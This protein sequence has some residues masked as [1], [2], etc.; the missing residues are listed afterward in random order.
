M[1]DERMI[2]GGLTCWLAAGVFLLG[3]LV[4]AVRLEDVQI[5]SKLE[6]DTSMERQST[7]RV[8]TAG[9][10][11]RI[12]GTDRSGR[13]V[14]LAGNRPS[15]AIAV[16]PEFFQ[17]RTVPG[18][19]KRIREAIDS[20]SAV[21]GQ[22]S[23]VTDQAI[24][25]HLEQE[26]ALPLVVWSDVSPEALARFAEHSR[27]L[28]GFSFI[29]SEVR[30]YPYG[31][32]AAHLL[33]YVGRGQ[34]DRGP[35]GKT[36]RFLDFEMRGRAGVE[37]YYDSFLR[38]MSG[39]KTLTVD[40]RGYVRESVTVIE[41]K[42]GPDLEMTL[43]VDIQAAA[44]EQLRGCRG[45][46]VV[47]DPR[48]GAVLALA[49][50]P[51]FD[52]N[53]FVPVL[54]HEVY[55][56]LAQDP[57]KPLLNRASGG[58]YAPGS[59]FKPI[60]ALAGLDAGLSGT[61]PYECIGHFTCGEMRIRCA[62]SWGH[63]SM[64]VKTSLRDSCNSYFCNFGMAMGTNALITAARAF[65][66][67][68]RTGIDLGQ[69]SA[70]IVPDGAWKQE[71]RNER[72]Y[73]GDLAQ[74]S[75]GQ[76]MLLVSPLQMARVAGALGTG[77]LV[78]PHLK[79]GLAAGSDPVPFSAKSFKTV[80]EG[81]RMVVHGGT[82]RKGAEGVNA[83]V[84]GKTGTAEVGRGERR[85]KNTW[86]IAYAE[87]CARNADGEQVRLD[88]VPPESPC[89]AVA[90]VIENGESGGGTTAPKVCA[91]LRRIYGTEADDVE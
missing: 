71:R 40:A 9:P 13:R 12:L 64:D 72:W 83:W 90:M 52:P 31:S 67:G 5:D 87:P 38:G 82:G 70:G 43:D 54:R 78:T 61:A 91:V 74:M 19:A 79:A 18:V 37:D 46:C 2:P 50:A 25:R 63:G 86:F 16:H 60:T 14:E 1:S 62:R 81:M 10:R 76:G 69:D 47:M 65:G 29:D 75:L 66:L 73:P 51:G 30:T 42:R 8:R 34:V 35:G 48:T 88:A 59:T 53:D 20:A 11:G 68:S 58:T 77:R 3:L 21:V 4:L 56:R 7:R 55:D 22:P 80:R 27:E 84:I 32:L 33:G 23:P 49:S 6:A 85:R 24:R 39:E 44:E 45:A 28:P 36:Y 57:E 89:V 17:S 15:V 41:A 26:L